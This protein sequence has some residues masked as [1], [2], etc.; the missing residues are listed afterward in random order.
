MIVITHRL[1]ALDLVDRV[2]VLNEGKIVA[3][4]P[5]DKVIAALQGK[6]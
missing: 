6:R 1:T 5:K 2:I 4:G 3:D